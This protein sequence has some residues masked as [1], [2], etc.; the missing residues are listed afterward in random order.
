VCRQASQQRPH[1]RLFIGDRGDDSAHNVKDK[2]DAQHGGL[3]EAAVRAGSSA[4]SVFKT[5]LP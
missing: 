5:N 2:E 3:S 4:M 1:T